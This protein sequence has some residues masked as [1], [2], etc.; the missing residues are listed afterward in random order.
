M[1]IPEKS[2]KQIIS[3]QKQTI[4]DQKQTISDQKQ[5]ISDQKQTICDIKDEIMTFREVLK[6]TSILL[7]NAIELRDPYT[8]GHSDH[9][10][11]LTEKIARLAFSETF[12]NFEIV[13]MA[14]LLHDVG[15][16]GISETVLNKPTLLTDAEFI[17]VKFHTNLGERLV[18]PLMLDNLL[19]EA[20]LHHHE[21]FDGSGYP[22]GL[23]GQEIPL[24]ARIIRV[25]DYFDALTSSRPYRAAM[26]KDKAIEVMKKNQ[27]CFDP[28]IFKFFTSN[29]YRLTRRST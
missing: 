24:I 26:S 27:H 15:K 13:K 3:D 10:S 14:A 18:K 22:D 28:E 16:I 12:P 29:I 17:M 9:V 23:R 1:D 4:S 19:R 20:I 25:A 5:I 8:K 2:Q 11:E 21:N 6:R 7:V